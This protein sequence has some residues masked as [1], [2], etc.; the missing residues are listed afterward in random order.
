MMLNLIKKIR[1]Y[2]VISTSFM[3]LQGCT[4]LP[5]I[6]PEDIKVANNIIVVS[7]EAGNMTLLTP[8]GVTIAEQAP[9]LPDYWPIGKKLIHKYNLPDPNEKI[10]NRFIA[11]LDKETKRSRFINVKPL[12]TAK[13]ASTNNLKEKYISGYILKFSP[14]RWETQYL[15]HDR[16]HYQMLFDAKVELMRIEDRRVIWTSTCKT[17]KEEGNPGAT[18]KQLLSEDSQV[19][20]NWIEKA[21]QFCTLKFLYDFKK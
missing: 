20:N 11:A 12:L 16:L 9:E 21:A 10:K 13:E 19:L 5:P 4:N 3:L 15:A 14:E 8:L 6:N 7:Q 2:S 17:Q 1:F 18:L